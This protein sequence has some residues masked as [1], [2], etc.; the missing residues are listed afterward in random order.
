MT[1]IKLLNYGTSCLVRP[2]AQTVLDEFFPYLAQ[3]I[4]S[5]TG[6]VARNDL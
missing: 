4:T 6:C 5:M 1:A 2:T 3:M